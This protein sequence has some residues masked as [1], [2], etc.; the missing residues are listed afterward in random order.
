MYGW[1]AHGSA[2]D[3]GSAGGAGAVEVEA[4]GAPVEVGVAVGV[5][6]GVDVAPAG[7]TLPII[8]PTAATVPPATVSTLRARADLFM[9]FLSALSP[10][11]RCQWHRA[12]GQIAVGRLMAIG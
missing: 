9:L 4:A 7:S 1:V 2:L 6:V 10:S 8:K 3:T 5:A 11:P 12:S